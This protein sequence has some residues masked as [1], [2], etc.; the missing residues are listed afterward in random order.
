MKENIIRTI[1]IITF[2]L[3]LVAVGLLAV[4]IG[5]LDI[6]P[7]KFLV[8]LSVLLVAVLA[9]L[10]KFLVEKNGKYQN[11]HC[12]IARIII[13]V[14][15]VMMIVVFAVGNV[16]LFKAH[17]TMNAITEVPVANA[18]VNV[19]V[20]KDDPAEEMKDIENYTVGISNSF[21]VENTQKALEKIKDQEG[22]SL[23]TVTF[24]NVPQMIQALYSGE[25]QAFLVNNA[26]VKVLND[27]DSYRD[28]AD[29]S[30]VLCEISVES[31]KSQEQTAATLPDQLQNDSDED[32]V[33]VFY[34]SGSDTRSEVL[35]TS[36]SDTNILVTVN[37]KTK[38]IL[39]LNTPRDYYIGNPA[40]GGALDKL[41]HCGNY[42]PE[43]SIEAL[44]DLYDL[45]IDYYAQIN[46]T[47]F[48]TLIDAVGGVTIYADE[49][50]TN[51]GVSIVEGENHLNGAE[52]L[53]FARERYNLSGG[54]N[55]RGK[56]QMK[57]IKAIIEKLSSSSVITH[58][59]D[60]MNSLQNM[61]VTSVPR[62]L[63]SKLVKMQINDMP[64]WNV[65][66]FAVTGYDD[67]ATTASAPGEELYVMRPNEESVSHAKELLKMIQGGQILTEDDLNP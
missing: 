59:S 40:Y 58:Y 26:Y 57:V 38:E 31:E 62:Q 7:A 66:S 51:R 22:F 19:Y 36:R 45:K 37:L 11:K 2:I 1:G 55:A 53:V 8:L 50:F 42:G 15:S 24:E 28:F 33:L 48:E 56:N 43:C 39:L 29:R 10:G 25:I 14:I 13:I 52:A 67:F 46:F 30:R 21:D 61:F 20:L 17:Q 32:D 3:L 9:V 44:S 47:G 54:D 41:T 35:D 16:M 6:L 64:K 4:Q 23:E 65:H 27:T 60:I 18:S 12:G 63:I 5:L 34:L 49:A